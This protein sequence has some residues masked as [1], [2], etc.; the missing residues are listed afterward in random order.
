MSKSDLEKL[1]ELRL[2]KL[3]LKQQREL[4]H[5]YGHKLYPWQRKFLE[6]RNRMNFLT[7]ANQVGKSSIAIK[8][9]LR[10]I[11]DPSLW[12][13]L[14]PAHCKLPFDKDMWME[15]FYKKEEEREPCGDLPLQ[16]W[17]LYPDQK[18]ATA[19][20]H[21][22][23]VRECLPSGSMKN[24][25]I[26]GW[27]AKFEKKYIQEIQFNIGITLYFK[28]YSQNPQSLQ[29]GTVAAIFC[30]EELPESLY[31]ELKFRLSHSNGYWHM[32]F[33]ATLNQELWRCTMEEKGKL[34]K[35]PDAFKMQI[36][37][38]DC[39]EFEDGTKSHWTPELIQS[40]IMDCSTEVEV[41]R[42]IHGKFVTEQGK[43][44]PHYHPE[45]STLE[46][47]TVPKDWLIYA[48]VDVGSG[49]KKGHP[50]AIVFVAVKP[51]FSYGE[52]FLGWRGD[53][54][55]TTAGDVLNKY[56]YMVDENGL[57]GRVVEKRYDYHCRD[58]FVIAQR[59]G[60][61]FEPANKKHDDGE[62]ILNSLFKH[63]S[64]KIHLTDEL[65][66]LCT[67]L[68]NLLVDTDKRKAVDDFSDAL[69]YCVAT[70]PWDWTK[71]KVEKPL[72]KRKPKSEIDLRREAFVDPKD[73]DLKDELLSEIA[74][75]NALY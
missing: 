5:L 8:K 10:W 18:L 30:D 26:Y 24:H 29:A 58:F 14:W 39:M 21:E 17:Y 31:D 12:T 15:E 43:K 32:V 57:E 59:T 45:R 62:N 35:F 55:E 41:Q 46:P 6:S 2:L 64:L 66:K 69:R 36:S 37:L 7:A 50:S 65:E 25:P 52:V 38:F 70:I 19:E 22:K 63:N 48:G 20:F 47:K 4:P 33:T 34:E 16:M 75:W 53:G 73:D 44:Y 28:T 3:K 68:N 67:E 71:I 56:F 51:D 42:R 72:I 61:D 11:T 9:C 60:E 54:I 49:G 40:R 27:K 1:E 23:W 13:E 74:E